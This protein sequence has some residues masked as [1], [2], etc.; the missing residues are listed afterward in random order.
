[1]NPYLKYKV[2]LDVQN[3]KELKK[4]EIVIFSPK[5]NSFIELSFITR[6]I[7]SK[8]IVYNNVINNYIFNLYLIKLGYLFIKK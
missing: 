1:M 3:L 4:E 2:S 5:I 8:S 7:F 6:Y